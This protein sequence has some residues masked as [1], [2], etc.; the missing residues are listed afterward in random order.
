MI[1][2]PQHAQNFCDVNVDQ[3]NKVTVICLIL[4]V[5]QLFVHLV[6]KSSFLEAGVSELVFEFVAWLI[7]DVWH[8]LLRD[9]VYVL[10]KWLSLAE[11]P[12]ISWY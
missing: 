9:V 6:A 7:F 5:W 3:K 12:P 11:Y 8:M 2:K 4:A 1:T 10:Q